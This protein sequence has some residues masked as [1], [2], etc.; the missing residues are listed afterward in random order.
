MCEFKMNESESRNFIYHFKMSPL[1]FR[2]RI[3][4]QTRADVHM[5]IEIMLTL[6]VL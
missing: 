3:I 1:E 5:A 6:H 2:G 4:Q